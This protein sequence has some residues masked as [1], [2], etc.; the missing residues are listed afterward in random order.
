MDFVAAKAKAATHPI[1]SRVVNKNKGKQVNSKSLRKP[2][3]EGGF[4]TQGKPPPPENSK[5][6][7]E[8]PSCSSSHWLS[9]CD[10]F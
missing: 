6:K 9:C 4:S 10:K 7:P 3:R 8:C 2:P 5:K 1:F